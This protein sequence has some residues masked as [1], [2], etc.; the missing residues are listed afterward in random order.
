M[1]HDVFICHASEDK[2]DFVRPLHRALTAAKLKVW[3]DEDSIQWGGSL[4]GS[5]DRGLA[6]CTFG[7]V[8]LS[9]SFFSKAWPQRELQGLVQ[10]QI[11]EGRVLILPIYHGVTN[12]DVRSFSPP[13]ADALAIQSHE[14]LEEIAIKLIALLE[15]Q[16]PAPMFTQVSVGTDEVANAVSA[17]KGLLSDGKT[18]ALDDLLRDR[19]NRCL[20]RLN[21]SEF[22]PMLQFQRQE[23]WFGEF[24]RRIAAMEEALAVPTAIQAVIA[25]YGNADHHTMMRDSIERLGEYVG[26]PDGI[27]W[28]VELRWYP[29]VLGF[30]KMLS[31]AV[32]ADKW[33][34]IRPIAVDTSIND[35]Q[36]DRPKPMILEMPPNQFCSDRSRGQ[37]LLDDEY[38]KA[39]TSNRYTPADEYVVDRV[40]ETLT[41]LGIRPERIEQSY[42]IA[43]FI[44]QLAFLDIPEDQGRYHEFLSCGQHWRV[45]KANGWAN[46]SPGRLM[47]RVEVD[48]SRAPFL[49]TGLAGGDVDHLLAAA[50]QI[51]GFM[52]ECARK[53]QW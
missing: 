1:E 49:R 15:R 7:I 37:W 43:L 13:L 36:R 38:A 52:D 33:E 5:I 31:A 14:S 51:E 2:E 8:V 25:Y 48:R 11:A 42:D 9:Q 28:W 27:N 18:I 10:R 22:N 26:K 41:L 32:A 19:Q 12:D 29:V 16:S 35:W 50:R 45:A 39:S 4:S 17:A 46:T 20:D 24:R 21:S 47:K 34:N 6:R 23:E 3:Y 40:K 44:A 30:Y 53:R